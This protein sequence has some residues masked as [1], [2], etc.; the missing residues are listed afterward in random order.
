MHLAWS[1]VRCNSAI[2]QWGFTKQNCLLQLECCDIDRF[3]DLF[4]FIQSRMF[5]PIYSGI[6]SNL[7]TARDFKPKA[8]NVAV[9][10]LY[11]WIL[12]IGQK[13]PVGA[14]LLCRHSG[15][16]RAFRLRAIINFVL[17]WLHGEACRY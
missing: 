14:P 7:I 17:L 5:I 8:T 1:S 13:L 6:D 9:E 11:A 2:R 16:F 12:R 15:I 4:S 10:F 3:A